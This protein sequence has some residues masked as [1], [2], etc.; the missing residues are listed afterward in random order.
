MLL[1][2]LAVA[3]AVQTPANPQSAAPLAQT[4]PGPVA[5]HG[6]V[7]VPPQPALTEQIM[8]ADAELFELFFT[9]ACDV[10]RLRSMIADG[11]EFYHDRRGLVNAD[12]FVAA[13]M[14]DCRRRE[15][16]DAPRVRREVMAESLTVSPMP[17]YGAFQ[18]G[19]HQF[20]DRRTDADAERLAG[21]LGFAHLWVLGTDGKWRVSRVFSYRLPRPAAAPAP[22]PGGS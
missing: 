12:A 16:P 9:G 20:Y 6:Q 1:L 22:A 14:E 13:Y 3:A 18:T 7:Q 5:G 17:G 2:A 11:A 8:G 21:R 19:V 15:A 4:S 10:P